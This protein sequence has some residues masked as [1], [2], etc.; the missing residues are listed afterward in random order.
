MKIFW[1]TLI[2][3]MLCGVLLCGG[4]TKNPRVLIKTERGDIA[5][6]IFAKKAPVT[7]SNFLKYVD[8][9]L[10]KGACFYRVVRMDNQ[11]RSQIKIE[12]IQ[13]GLRFTHRDNILPPIEHETTQKTSVLHLDGTLSMARSKPGSA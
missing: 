3:I 7:A 4:E 13:G 5:V 9:G 11:P 10:F 6:E 1:R 12:V 8:E 2:L